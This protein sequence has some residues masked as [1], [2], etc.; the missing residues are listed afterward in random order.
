MSDE[1]DKEAEREKLRKKF[2]ED[3][4]KRSDTQRMSE[5][6][7]QGATMTNNHC[8]NCGDPLFRDNGQTFC[9]TCQSA[10][11]DAAAQPQAQD[12]QSPGADHQQ[13]GQE[14]AQSNPAA[15]E[16]QQPGNAAGTQAG[17]QAGAAAEH[18]AQLPENAEVIAQAGDQHAGQQPP[19]DRGNTQAPEQRGTAKPPEGGTVAGEPAAEL[20]RAVTETA[21]KAS[22]ATDP[23]TARAWLEA[24]KEAAEAL[25]ALEQ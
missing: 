10:G 7:L 19:A 1:F 2:A 16:Q 9:P 17:S 8:D 25:A 20:R 3:E 22:A 18:S 14:P 15:N 23:R 21:R 24:S 4:E 5:L 12:G 11:G 6:L 13:R